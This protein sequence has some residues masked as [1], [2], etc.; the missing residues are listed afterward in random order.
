MACPGGCPSSDGQELAL[1][2]AAHSA[3]S[4]A[5]CLAAFAQV[6]FVEDDAARAT[7]L[8]GAAEG[9][10]RRVGLRAWPM[11]RRPEAEL[12]ARLR[13]TLGTDRFGEVFAAG[14]RLSQQAAV[15]AV[16]DRNVAGAS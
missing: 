6:A 1:S 7:M 5:L 16:R 12:L 2:L 10:R 14:S 4:V 11:M 15:A 13:Q 9:L 3:H 8:A